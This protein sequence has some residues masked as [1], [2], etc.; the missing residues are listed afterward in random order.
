MANGASAWQ[1]WQRAAPNLFMT[2]Q[3]RQRCKAMGRGATA[4]RAFQMGLVALGRH[5]DLRDSGLE[6]GEAGV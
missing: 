4:A 5:S 2:L 1:R 3:A 6:E